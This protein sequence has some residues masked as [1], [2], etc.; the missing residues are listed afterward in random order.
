[1]LRLPKHAVSGASV[2]HRISFFLHTKIASLL[3]VETAVVGEA[4]AL[5]D[6]LGVVSFL[7]SM[8][9]R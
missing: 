5:A 8:M 4:M 7:E 3:K 9:K 1:M 2:F 6:S